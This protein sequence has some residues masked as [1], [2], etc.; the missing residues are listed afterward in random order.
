MSTI[1]FPAR[2]TVSGFVCTIQE[3]ISAFTLVLHQNTEGASPQGS[4][5]VRGLLA[6]N[7]SPFL[8]C[9]VQRLPRPGLTVTI[10]GQIAVYQFGVL[11]LFVDIISPLC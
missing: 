8:P 4:L 6:M 2:A 1:Q 7:P 11:V 10:S 3:D 9:A 5:R